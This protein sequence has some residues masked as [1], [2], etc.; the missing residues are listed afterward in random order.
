M[1]TVELVL[2]GIAIVGGLGLL[3]RRAYRR[4]GLP[5][6]E[7]AVR[8]P[9]NDCQATVAVR[10]DPAAQT[11]AQYVDVV[12]CSLH[13][14]AVV[15]LPERTAWLADAPSV[16]VKLEPARSCP[17]TTVA[18]DQGCVHVLNEAASPVARLPLDCTSGA[19]DAID[20]VRQA[21]RRP[22]ITRLLWYGG[23]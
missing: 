1:E 9:E 11:C 23:A 12:A 21:E 22:R 20:L 19:A 4:S 10:T 6:T 13:P 7:V 5:V 17:A 15:Q 3:A 8:C 16:P 14:G 2:V 18:C